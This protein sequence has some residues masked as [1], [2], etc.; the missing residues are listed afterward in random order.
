MVRCDERMVEALAL[1]GA[2]LGGGGGGSLAKGLETGKLALALGEPTVVPLEAF[3]SDAVVITVSAVGAPAATEQYV[4]VAD[5]VSAVEMLADAID[6]PVEGLIT[7]EMGGMAS[8]NGLVQSAL[9]GVPVVDAPCNGRAQPTSTMGSMGLD[10]LTDYVSWQAAC[11]GNPNTG[12]Q[13]SLVISGTVSRCAKLVR[14][15]SVLAGGVV[16]VARN[17]IGAAY[18]RDHAA[19]GAM[20]QAISVGL[21]MLKAKDKGGKPEDEAA[22]VLSGE[23]VATGRVTKV[24]IQT[25]GG[26]DVGFVRVEGEHE[27]VFW[28]EYMLLETRGTR[29]FTF[30]DLIATFDCRQGLPVSSAEIREGMEVAV[31]AADRNRLIL[32]EGMRQPELFEAAEEAIGRPLI[33]YVFGEG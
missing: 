3:A 31:L 1:G 23:I 28:N 24:D 32:G 20:D 16:A 12:H 8:V 7:N 26:F 4:K 6:N 25:K 17:P 9:L 30:P 21:A 19:V 10:R 15:A 18:L 22:R 14:E 13:L 27:L 2:V 11:G 33:R 5:F 29:T